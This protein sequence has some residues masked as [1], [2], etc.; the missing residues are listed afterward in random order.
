MEE[1]LTDIHRDCFLSVPDMIRENG[2]PCEEI[3]VET[4]DGFLLGLQRMPN[5]NGPAVLLQH[6]LLADASNW[7]TGGPDHGLD[8]GFN[9]KQINLISKTKRIR[10]HL[11]FFCTS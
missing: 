11:G 9:K 1:N 7:V 5:E 10:A 3:T 8:F 4:E 2:F 6:G